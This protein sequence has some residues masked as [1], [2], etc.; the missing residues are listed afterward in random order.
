MSWTTTL[1]HTTGSAQ[2]SRLRYRGQNIKGQ[3][4]YER[5]GLLCRYHARWHN[6]TTRAS[7]AKDNFPCLSS[8][9][10]WIEEQDLK[11]A[12]RCA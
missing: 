10:Y 1:S 8:A 2:S 9:Q 12:R 6:P 4:D 11:Q 3:I 5:Q 7:G